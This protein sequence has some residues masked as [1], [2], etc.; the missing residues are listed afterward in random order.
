MY[1][2]T[3]LMNKFEKFALDRY[4][5]K[6]PDDWDFSQIVDFVNENLN[7]I[8]NDGLV[9]PRVN[10]DDWAGA[11]L[12]YEIDDLALELEAAFGKEE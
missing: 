6:Y 8:H 3:I 11:N 7:E 2:I 1:D 4:L 9:V 12:A 10:Y 5:R